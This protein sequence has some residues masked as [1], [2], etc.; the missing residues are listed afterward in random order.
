MIFTKPVLWDE[1]E[2]RAIEIEPPARRGGGL[3]TGLRTHV[4]TLAPTLG[5][6]HQST[7]GAA[8]VF[9]PDATSHGNF[10]EAS[11]RRIVARPEWARRLR[12]V[13]TAKRQ[14]RATGPEER[15][16]EWREL[17]AATSSDALLMNVFCYPRV[18]TSGLRALM[19]VA[20]SEPV[21][22]WGEVGSPAHPQPYQHDRDRYARRR[23]CWSKRS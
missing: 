3:A 4:G 17:D 13:H 5:K 22:V 9:E 18:W 20:G 2:M 8:V 1:A 6:P 23:F 10:I 16:R 7:R 21:E 11:Y 15:V 19:G 12:K 14:A